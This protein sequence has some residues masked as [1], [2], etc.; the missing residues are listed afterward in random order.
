ML[1]QQFLAS[2]RITYDDFDLDA[3]RHGVAKD[4]WD[5]LSACRGPATADRDRIAAQ[6]V[7]GD[8]RPDS[9]EATEALGPSCRRRR[10]RRRRQ[11]PPC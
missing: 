1:L 7:P 6:L 5:T 3:F 11:R 4:N 10:C 8:L 9:P 2:L